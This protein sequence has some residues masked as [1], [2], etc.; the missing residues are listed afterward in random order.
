MLEQGEDKG[1]FLE[2]ALIDWFQLY[3]DYYLETH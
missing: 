3:S 2:V 1:F